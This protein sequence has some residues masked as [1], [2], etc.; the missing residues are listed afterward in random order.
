M[1]RV[2]HQTT[3]SSPNPHILGTLPGMVTPHSLFQC[4]TT[5]SRKFFVSN[6]SSKPP[7]AQPEAASSHPNHVQ[8]HVGM[9][10][11]QRIPGCVPAPPALLELLLPA[12]FSFHRTLWA[13][14]WLRSH[15][16]ER[17]SSTG[18]GALGAAQRPGCCSYSAQLSVPASIITLC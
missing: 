7:L 6:I 17:G 14:L 2:H 11:A 8:E 9:V 5:L 1:Q 16:E 4:F 13:L 12:W 3:S 10:R 18:C 15:P